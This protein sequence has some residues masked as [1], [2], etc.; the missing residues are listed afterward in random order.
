MDAIEKVV[1]KNVIIYILVR[2]VKII[3]KIYS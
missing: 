2:F 1:I 3:T